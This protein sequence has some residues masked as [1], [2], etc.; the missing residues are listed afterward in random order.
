MMEAV[1]SEQGGSPPPPAEF[2][3]PASTTAAAALPRSLKEPRRESTWQAR[4]QDFQHCCQAH[5]KNLGS[6]AGYIDTSLLGEL[7]LMSC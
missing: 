6:G 7:H 1:G 4:S 5:G 3:T 2:Q